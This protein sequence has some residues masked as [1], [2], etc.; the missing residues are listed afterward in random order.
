MLGYIIRRA[1]YAVPTLIGV[2]LVIFLAMRVVPGDPVSVIYGEQIG[3]LRPQDRAKIERELG[4]TDPLAV[5]YGSWLKDFATGSFGHSLQTPDTVADI[6]KRR[7]PL[8]LEISVLAIVL[9]WLVGVPVGIVSALHQNTLVDYVARFFTVLFLAIPGFWLGSLIV[10]GL[11]LKFSYAAPLGTIDFWDDPVENL[12]I[13]WGPSVVLGLAVSSYISRMTR[14]T[15]LEVIREDYIR[16][17]RAKGLREKIVVWR[18]ALRNTMLP[19]LTLSG[20]LFGFM[21]GGT[22][23]VEQAFNVPGLGRAMV[24]AFVDLDY[25]VIQTLVLLYGAVFIIINLLIDVSYAWLDPRIRYR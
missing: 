10:L 1:L 25:T 22:V 4:L 17:A 14:S 20:V 6:I 11:L 16:T 21:L 9:A 13:V 18:H 3:D 8:T 23:V 19:V 5:Q 24:E 12:Q 15:L 7:G 2:S